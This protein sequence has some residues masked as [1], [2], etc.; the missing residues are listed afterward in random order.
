MG[1]VSRDRAG[2]ASGINNS[3]SRIA[4]LLAIAV[5]GVILYHVFDRTLNEKIENLPAPVKQEIDQ[6][7][8]RLAA[9]KVND[10]QGRLA[11]EQSFFAGYRVILWIAA[12]LAV[13]SA[14]STALMIGKAA[15]PDPAP[16]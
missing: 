10:A 14:I 16:G 9:A 4:G 12:T 15:R 3:V 7:R 8:S 1:A 2:A 11:V 6:Q 13:A 5:F